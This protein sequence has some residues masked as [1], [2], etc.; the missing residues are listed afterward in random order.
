M[1][2]CNFHYILALLAVFVMCAWFSPGDAATEGNATAI[3][4]VDTIQHDALNA[5]TGYGA[6]AVCVVYSNQAAADFTE[7]SVSESDG[8]LPGDQIADT[9]I[10][11]TTLDSTHDIT[12]ESDG[13]LPGVSR[14]FASMPNG[15]PLY[16]YIA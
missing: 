2:S 4:D 12:S 13:G 3:S 11:S 9:L 10:P 15:P 8:G 7:S 5:V 1:R 14:R 6:T 16:A